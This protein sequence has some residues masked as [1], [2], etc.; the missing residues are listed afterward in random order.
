M[1]KWGYLI[2]LRSRV[3]PLLSLFIR[4]TVILRINSGDIGM[5]GRWNKKMPT[6]I[7]I[8]SHSLGKFQNKFIQ[9][10][11]MKMSEPPKIYLKIAR[12]AD[13]VTNHSLKQ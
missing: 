6:Q 3:I 7:T 9:S 8:G 5:I 1:G 11:L 2:T 10:Y 12:G 4:G 13:R